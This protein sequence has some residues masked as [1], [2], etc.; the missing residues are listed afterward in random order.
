M[1]R[2]LLVDDEPSILSVLTTL[3]RKQGFEVVPANGG[4]AASQLINTERFDLLLT[5]IRMEPING[6]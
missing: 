1:A 3:L 6:L 5:D 2:I 4:E